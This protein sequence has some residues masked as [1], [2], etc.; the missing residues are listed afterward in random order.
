MPIGTRMAAKAVSSKVKKE[1]KDV[2]GLDDHD[3]KKHRNKVGKKKSKKK[4]RKRG[5]GIL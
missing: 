1:A 5:K 4:G 3:D 2:V